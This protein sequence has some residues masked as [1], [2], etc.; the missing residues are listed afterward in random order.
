MKTLSIRQSYASLICRGIKKVENRSWETKY[1]GKLL[2]HASGKP[3]VWPELK[4]CTD[5]FVREYYKYY[6]T[7]GKFT[8]KYITGYLNRLVFQHGKKIRSTTRNP[9]NR[10]VSNGTGLV[11]L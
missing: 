3:L 6:G 10:C 8:P 4:Y 5:K 9:L 2:I 11:V 7:N 1:R